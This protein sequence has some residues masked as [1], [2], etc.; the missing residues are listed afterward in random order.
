MNLGWDPEICSRVS[1]LSLSLSTF[2]TPLVFVSFCFPPKD[3]ESDSGIATAGLQNTFALDA[4]VTVDRSSTLFVG[5]PDRW[6]G[7]EFTCQCRRH[8][9]H[10]FDPWVRKIPWSMKWQPTPVFLPGES[11]RTE[12]SGS[13]FRVTEPDMT[14]DS[15]DIF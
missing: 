8:K 4:A 11:P 7:K 13:L 10:G 5:F 14:K 9:R 1:C 3:S 15:T 6:V 2:H 12:E